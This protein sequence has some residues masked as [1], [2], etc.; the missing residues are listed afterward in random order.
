[1][2]QARTVLVGVV[3]MFALVTLAYGQGKEETLK[4]SITC[5]KCDLKLEAKCTTVIVVDVGG[6]KTT[7]YFD[8][9]AHSKNH[10]EVCQAAKPGT[11]VGE[12]GKTGDKATVKVK[13]V[14]F[15]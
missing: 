10:K 2:N 15:D 7:Y 1:M 6:K 5:A 14:K 11:V 13:S 4:G 12:T 3:L 9:A 8:A